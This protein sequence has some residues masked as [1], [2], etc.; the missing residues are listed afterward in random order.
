MA[1]LALSAS[2]ALAAKPTHTP[3][4]L[5]PDIQL[6]AGEVCDF[7]V[8]LATTEVRAKTTLWEHEDGTVRFMERGYAEGYAAN[9]DG[10]RVPYGG[11]YRIE[12]V[13]HPDGSAEVSASGTLFAWYFAGDSIVGLRAPGAYAVKG[14]G[15]ESYA[16]DGSLVS[17]RFYGGKVIDL[18]EVLAPGAGT[19]KPPVIDP[20]VAS[21]VGGAAK[22]GKVSGRSVSR[23]VR[24]VAIAAASLRQLTNAAGAARGL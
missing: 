17:A 18:C 15:S 20:G 4:E 12:V 2:P 21:G 23:T 19:G 10:D 11:G 13:V 24:Q 8:T 5:A 6:A 14:R 3:A 7:A 16:A 22:L 1:L 9:A